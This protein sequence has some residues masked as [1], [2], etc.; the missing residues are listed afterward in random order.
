[1]RRLQIQLTDEQLSRLRDLAAAQGRSMADVIRDSVD[2]FVRSARSVD[3]DELKK[4]ALDAVGKFR[5]DKSDVSEHHDRYLAEA[6]R[7]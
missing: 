6:Y 3:R 5:S 1:M 7:K 4:R 2:R